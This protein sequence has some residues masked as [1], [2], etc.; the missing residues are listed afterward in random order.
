MARLDGNFTAIDLEHGYRLSAPGLVGN[1]EIRDG[2]KSHTRGGGEEQAS[3]AFD[4]V[5]ESSKVFEIRS[6]SLDVAEQPLPP[7]TA[8]TRTAGGEEGMVLEV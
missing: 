7:Q 6:I 8:P 2:R 1:A 4:A 5:L 3:P